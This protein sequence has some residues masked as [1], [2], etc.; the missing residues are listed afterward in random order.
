MLV[1]K[2]IK[3]K[4]GIAVIATVAVLLVASPF[5]YVYAF[6]GNLFGWQKSNTS[7]EQTPTIN[8]DKPTQEQIDAGNDAKSDSDDT[9]DS[10]K[11]ESDQPS[12]VTLP[13]GKYSADV[14]IID[15]GSINND[16]DVSIR[17][18][19]DAIDSQ[20]KCTLNILTKSGAVAVNQVADT[21]AQSSYSSCLGFIVNK[22]DLPSGTYTVKITYSSNTHEGSA[23]A[24][25]KL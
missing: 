14:T 17:A 13:S 6:N 11:G 21:Q 25:L 1:P 9:Y 3:N 20:G 23:S 22:S 12:A 19:V 8:Y 24:E 4:K 15:S 2:K 5:V 16:G 10:T 7:K 18:S